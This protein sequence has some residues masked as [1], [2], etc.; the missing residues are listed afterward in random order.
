MSPTA[1]RSGDATQVELVRGLVGRHARQLVHD[2]GQLPRPPQR[3]VA[4]ES[5]LLVGTPEL[6]AP[7]I[8]R[9]PQRLLRAR[10]DQRPLR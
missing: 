3:L 4:V 7:D 10:R 1:P 9:D 5:A 2:R 8:P 6:D